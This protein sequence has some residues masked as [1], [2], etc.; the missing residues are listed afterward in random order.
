[1]LGI[2]TQS[3]P[4]A[5]S[6]ALAGYLDNAARHGRDVEVVIVDDSPSAAARADCRRAL[7][8]EA[9]ARGA[10]ILYAGAEEKAAFANALVARGLAPDLVRFALSPERETAQAAGANRNALL[11][12]TAGSAVFS[13]DDD[14]VCRV[15]AAP[16]PAAGVRLSSGHDPADHW[17]FPDREAAL[18]AVTF[19]DR[20]V[21]GLHEELLGRGAASLGPV[22]T[23]GAGGALRRRFEAGAGEVLVTFNGLL[24]DSGWGAPFGFWHA[25]MGYLAMR[26]ASLAR[27]AASESGYR[28]ACESREILR[29][30]D[31]PHVG[32]AAFSMTTFAALDNRRP[33]PPFCPLGRGQDNVFGASVS[34][35]FPG[36]LFG[37]L[38]WA[39]VHAPVEARRFWPGEMTRSAAGVDLGRVVLECLRSVDPGAVASPAARMAALGGHLVA[40]GALPQPDFDAFV[41]ARLRASGGAFLAWL[42]ERL[43]A[44]RGAPAWWAADVAAYRS[45][46]AEAIERPD[47]GVP[48]DLRGPDAAAR[49]RALVGRFGALL[50]AW[51]DVVGAAAELR[52]AGH[53]LAVEARRFP[54]S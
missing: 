22:D 8:A 38:P 34:L 27:L 15:A 14:T 45:A 17:F 24:G 47:Y 1:V 54:L 5:L 29:V 50:A 44:E 37:H 3:R 32:D 31:R 2:V 52:R 42:D 25:P 6:R 21:L 19:V 7:G 49:C 48:L 9:R 13:A 36:A 12:H 33:L 4:E 18:D 30:V 46:L 51:P 11:L 16:S 23:G 20:D 53:G 10:R 28:L 40:L 41:R 35:C 26:G 43:A 39:L